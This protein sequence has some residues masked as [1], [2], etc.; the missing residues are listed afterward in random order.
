MSIDFRLL[1]EILETLLLEQGF[2]FFLLTFF[3]FFVKF[4]LLTFDVG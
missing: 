3:Q 1:H 4:F 2:L